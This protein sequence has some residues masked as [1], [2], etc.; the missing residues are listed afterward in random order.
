MASLE[1]CGVRRGCLAT[2]A[3]ALIR[4]RTGP[5]CSGGRILLLPLCRP[6]PPCMAVPA[7]PAWAAP[8]SRWPN[9][10]SSGQGAALAVAT[11]VEAAARTWGTRFTTQAVG[12][13][14]PWAKATPSM[15]GHT[16]LAAAGGDWHR[17]QQ[18]LEP[19]MMAGNG[20]GVR[21]CYLRSR[22]SSVP[23]VAWSKGVAT[24]AAMRPLHS[25]GAM[26]PL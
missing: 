14:A 25:I 6:L 18:M 10:A 26:M 22:V 11:M 3:T 1:P 9:S 7:A 2:A 20:F 15:V 17:R 24:D 4:A 8:G 5:G 21:Q 12:S 23:C 19:A 13:G 16:R